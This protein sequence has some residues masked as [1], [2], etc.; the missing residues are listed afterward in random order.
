MAVVREVL[1]VV[2][3]LDAEIELTSAVCNKLLVLLL[4][5]L[6]TYCIVLGVVFVDQLFACSI[7][8]LAAE[9]PSKN[10]N[11]PGVEEFEPSNTFCASFTKL[12]T[13]PEY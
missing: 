6:I 13:L 8:R 9:R 3:K 7:K 2:D 4:E 12:E 11:G 1:I 10:V 5:S